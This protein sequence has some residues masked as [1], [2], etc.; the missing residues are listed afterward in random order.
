[1]TLLLDTH[2]ILWLTEQVPRLGNAARRACDVALT[3]N[4]LAVST[5]AFY[6]AGRLLR[7]GR[8]EG[9]STLR[10]WRVQLLSLGVREILVSPEIAM[11]AAELDDLH[12]DPLD[13]IIVATALVEDAILLTADRPILEWAGKVRRQDA[14][15]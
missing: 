8:V 7:R 6:E 9:P 1:M 5:V 2:T 12:G 4:E 11:L 3:A 13:R 10:G 15:R 14:R